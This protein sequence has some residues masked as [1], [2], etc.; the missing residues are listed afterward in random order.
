MRVLLWLQVDALL[1]DVQAG[2]APGLHVDYMHFSPPCQDLS[3][4]KQ[5]VL[6]KFDGKNLM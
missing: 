5:L 4:Q 1:A 3:N 2:R 6:R